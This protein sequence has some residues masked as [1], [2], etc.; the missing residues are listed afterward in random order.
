[1]KVLIEDGAARNLFPIVVLRIHP[2]DGNRRRVVLV[3]NAPG[4]LD[5]GDGFQNGEERAAERAGLL[6][7][8]DCD[9][10][11]IAQ[12]IARRNRCGW[13]TALPL[14]RFDDARYSISTPGVRLRARDRTAP[15][16]RG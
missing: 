2:E 3:G 11:W 14:L 8:H 9:C 10:S 4:E 5:R 13:G 1:L 7:G 16:I 15:G 6:A 12:H